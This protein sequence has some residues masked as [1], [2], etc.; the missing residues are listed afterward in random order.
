MNGPIFR[1]GAVGVLALATAAYLG[2]TYQHEKTRRVDRT[3]AS[4]RA[5]ADRVGRLIDADP[6][7]LMYVVQ[8]LADRLTRDKLAQRQ[9]HRALLA[10][11]EKHPAVARALH[12]GVS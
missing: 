10:N 1:F 2:L 9:L 12:R 3:Q 11:I 5:E 4:V 6:S 8:T 7:S